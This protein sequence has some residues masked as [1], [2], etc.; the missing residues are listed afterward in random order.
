MVP[1]DTTK[2]GLHDKYA[3]ADGWLSA[4]MTASSD[5]RVVHEASH[6]T[7][8]HPDADRSDHAMEGWHGGMTSD[9]SDEKGELQD[10]E[11]RNVLSGR[12]QDWRR[13][14]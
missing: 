2:W 7:N 5:V 12:Q 9:R 11:S 8:V 6:R 10:D 14:G 1:E 4:K 13:A 3:L